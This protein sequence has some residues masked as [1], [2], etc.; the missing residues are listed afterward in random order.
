MFFRYVIETRNHMDDIYVSKQT[1]YGKKHRLITKCYLLV[2]AS[3][4]H[5]LRLSM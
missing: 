1:R 2:Y 3:D 5:Y 4:M